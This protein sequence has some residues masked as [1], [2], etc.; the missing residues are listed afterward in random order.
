MEKKKP[1]NGLANFVTSPWL[2]PGSCG[3]VR[4]EDVACYTLHVDR[5]PLYLY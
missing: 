2:L 4:L 1:I 5:P 3:L